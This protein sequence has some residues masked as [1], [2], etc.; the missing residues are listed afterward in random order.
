MPDVSNG[1]FQAQTKNSKRLTMIYRQ[2]IDGF[3]VGDHVVVHN[4]AQGSD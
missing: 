4:H 3:I 2:K 1:V